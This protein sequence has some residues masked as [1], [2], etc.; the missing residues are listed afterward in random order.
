MS[1]FFGF[2]DECGSYQIEKTQKFLKV[3]PFYIRSSL[4]IKTDE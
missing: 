1:I 2:S 3:H 4:L